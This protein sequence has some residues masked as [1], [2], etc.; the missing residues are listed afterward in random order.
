MAS[1]V[2]RNV[3]D[4]VPPEYGLR[5]IEHKNF[6]RIAAVKRVSPCFGRCGHIFLGA[7]KREGGN[8]EKDKG[9][10]K[11]QEVFHA[12]SPLSNGRE[13]QAAELCVL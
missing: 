12:M 5:I 9:G 8:S 2:S 10:N 13:K 11:E 3:G 1:G 4:T 7:G 6:F